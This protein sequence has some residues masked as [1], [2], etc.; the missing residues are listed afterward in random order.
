[1]KRG[2]RP[3]RPTMTRT[4]NHGV[5]A[6]NEFWNGRNFVKN[7]QHVADRRPARRE[8]SAALTPAAEKRRKEIIAKARE[9][10][11]WEDYHALER[12]IASQT[13]NAPQ[14]YNSGTYIM[15]SPGW[16]LIVRERLDTRLIPTRRA[17]AHRPDHPPLE[18][19]PDRPL[20]RQH[21]GRRNDE[22]HRQAAIGR[23][24]RGERSGRHSL[25]ELSSDRTLRAGQPQIESSTTPRSSIP[26]R[27]RDPGRSI[28]RGR[29][30]HGYRIFEYACHE[31]NY[32]LG[33]SLSGERVL[34]AEAAK[35][36]RGREIM[37]RLVR[38][39]IGSIAA[40]AVMAVIGL[41]VAWSAAQGVRP[42]GQIPRTPDGKP[43]LNGIWQAMNTANYDLEDHGTAPSSVIVTGAVGATF[44]GESVVEGGRIPYRAEALAKRDANRKSSMPGKLGRILEA[45]PEVN[46]FLPGV[47]RATY[48]P[49]PFQIFQSPKVIWIVYQY[50]YARRE[51]P[52][53]KPS[54]APIESWMGWSNG[55]WEGD[56]LVVDVT[57]FNDQTW[58]DRAG[59]YHSDALHVI[60]RYTPRQRKSPDVRSD[61]RGSSG[62]YAALDDHD[63]ALSPHGQ[64]RAAPGV[65]VPGG[66]R[67]AAR[68]AISK[69][70]PAAVD[71]RRPCRFS[72]D[73]AAKLA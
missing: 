21:A 63:A 39:S 25:R 51:I 7:L 56:T 54:K 67:R 12:C 68:G 43:D 36:R 37:P 24:V 38:W 65:Q 47:P 55:H 1:M 26:R 31:G 16:V 13:P 66:R 73:Q 33:N 60:E 42:Q 32:A 30:M 14:A 19:R 4:P 48:L 40:A 69:G 15:Q 34:E 17:P 27:G 62:L 41:A 29:G 6:Y 23:H 5:G 58:F 45:D 2:R 71:G 20:G 61:D 59:N 70:Y 44:P 28:F 72:P 22:F 64:E 3:T 8:I 49:H 57:A 9:F 52:L 18:W 53:D 46:C 11:S 10:A 35:K 50:S